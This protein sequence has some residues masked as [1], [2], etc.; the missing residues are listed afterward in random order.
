M[1]SG[2]N[3]KMGVSGVAQFK[4]NMNQAK[5]AVKTLDAQLA[6]SEKQ[7]KASGD[8]EGYMTE[9]TE[10][11]KAKL[12][13]QKSVVSN[14]E[15]AL[16]NMTRNGVDRSSA[17]YQSLYQQMLKAKGEMLDTENAMNGVAESGDEAAKSV[18]SMNQQLA[19]IGQGVSW[20]NVTDGLGKITDGMA[21]VIKTA[22][23]V[24]KAIATA[25]LGAGQWADE[26][27]ETADK[28]E[29]EPEHLYRMQETARVIDTDAETILAAQDKLRKN[30]EKEDK[31]AMGALAYL[32]VDPTGKGNID[33]FWEAGEA[34]AAL[35]SEEDKVSYANSLFGKQWDNGPGS[36]TKR[37]KTWGKW[38]TS[39]SIWKAN[40]TR[41]RENSKRL[42]HRR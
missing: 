11:L 31:S 1:A 2:V 27:Q 35:G 32:G 34:I 12:E 20:E 30:I 28:Y 25:T 23:D 42:W 24:G 9:K 21:K 22:W 17:A 8:A 18:D 3:V 10:L 41:S 15:K 40:G 37:L 39:T 33:I 26:L 13:Q 38:T 29:I 5:N 14:A 4:N 16:E 7:F 36:A 6:L 19:R